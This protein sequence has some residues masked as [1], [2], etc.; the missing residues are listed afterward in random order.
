MKKALSPGLYKW[1]AL[2]TV[3]TGTFLGTMDSTMVNIAIPHFTQVFRVGPSVALWVALAFMLG[4]TGSMLTLGRAA[5]VFGRKRVCVLGFLLV[6][7][8]LGLCALSQNIWQLIAFR[9]VQSIGAAMLVAVANAII[10]TAFPAEERGRA[11][12]IAGIAVGAGLT[13]GPA[14]G[15][16]L[17]DTLGW[18]AIFYVR[19][20]FAIA[21]LL[22][23]V[24]VLREQGT[25]E[26]RGHFDVKGA[27][28]LF[29][30][31]V[32]L[33]VGVNQGN[34][35]GWTS[36]VV[37]ACLAAG[38]GLFAA[39]I[40]IEMKVAQPVVA[41]NLFRQR[42]FAVASASLAIVFVASRMANFVLP[43]LLIQ[44]LAL[45]PLEAGLIL[46][47]TP[48]CMLLVSPLAGRLSDRIGSRLLTTAGLVAVSCGYFLVSRL[49]I[50]SS[51]H[52]IVLSLLLVGIG[53][54][55]FESPNSSSIMG[56]V[57]SRRLGTASAMIGTLR[58][59]GQSTGIAIGGAIFA[60]SLTHHASGGVAL[61]SLAER[62]VVA[63]AFHNTI[64]V[65]MVICACAALVAALRGR[66]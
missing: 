44:A 12:G 14:I 60:G 35:L 1:L 26:R 31:L 48:L 15:G 64:V 20:P 58:T 41:L 9:V 32:S 25:G 24:F 36:P 62:Q 56:S 2:F 61:A 7:V 50:D 21:A 3:S 43:F 33:L 40:F 4:S 13:S 28:S 57:P 38:T 34:T 59:V 39:F 53:M 22:L 18:R 5:D 51:P 65:A 52:T 55:L 49:G 46:M 37:V 8:G 27:L 17:L 16:F 63:L 19:L 66:G 11:I 47:T 30:G 23:G 10:T 42:L 54:G 45:A 29:L 6:V